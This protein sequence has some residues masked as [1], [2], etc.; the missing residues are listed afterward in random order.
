MNIKYLLYITIGMAS[1]SALTLHPKCHCQKQY[2]G[3]YS[4]TLYFIKPT[5]PLDDLYCVLTKNSHGYYDGQPNIRGGSEQRVLCTTIDTSLDQ[6]NHAFVR[7]NDLMRAIDSDQ[8]AHNVRVIA[9][10][11]VITLSK[12]LVRSLR[13][14]STRRMIEGY[15]KSIIQ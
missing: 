2:K 4:Y 10:H 5:N 8:P 1:F 13:Q 12:P 15:V 9:Q 11:D 3:V 6:H 14:S 7:Y